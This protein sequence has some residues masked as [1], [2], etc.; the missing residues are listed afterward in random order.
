MRYAFV[1]ENIEEMRSQVGIDDVELREAIRGLWVG[2]FVGLTLLIGTMRPVGETVTVRLTRIVGDD[3]Q[4]KLAE[5][6]ASAGLSQLRCGSLI[7]FTR[8]H[9]HSLSEGRPTHER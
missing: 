4:G 7:T 9:I 2:D 6:P 1:I 5:K 8:N 3:F